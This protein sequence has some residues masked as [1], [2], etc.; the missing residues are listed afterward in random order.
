MDPRFY[1]ALRGWLAE[2]AGATLAEHSF[3][4]TFV[5]AVSVL[6]VSAIGLIVLGYFDD[7]VGGF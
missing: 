5:A 6:S 3:V 1:R 2:E 4:L 7:I